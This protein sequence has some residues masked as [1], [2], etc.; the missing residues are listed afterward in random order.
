MATTSEVLTKTYKPGDTVE[1]SGIYRVTHDPAHREPHEVTVV[2]GK[3][4]P[5]CGKCQHPR[6]KAVRLAHHIEMHEDFKRA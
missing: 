2:F 5:P 4:F 3:R 6:F 1:S